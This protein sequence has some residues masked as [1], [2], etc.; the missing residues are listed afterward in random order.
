MLAPAHR[1]AAEDIEADVATIQPQPRAS[2][3]AIEGCWGAAFHWIAYGCQTKHG[4][5]RE[6]HIRLG[7]FL[8]GL[9]EPLVAGWWEQLEGLRQG[10]WYGGHFDPADVQRAMDFLGDVRTWATS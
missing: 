7:A 5:H 4:Q 3:L 2:R 9:G 10:G 6:T 1:Q 8:R